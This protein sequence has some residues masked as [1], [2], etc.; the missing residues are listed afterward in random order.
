[1]TLA[2]KI[3]ALT[4]GRAAAT[5][6]NFMTQS[7]THAYFSSFSFFKPYSTGGCPCA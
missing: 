1:M 2:G 3:A 5:Y 4:R 6:A 7:A